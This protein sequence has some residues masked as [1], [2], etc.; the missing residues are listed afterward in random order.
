MDVL[1]QPR[2]GLND[3]AGTSGPLTWPFRLQTLQTGRDYKALTGAW[4]TGTT[5]LTSWA[6]IPEASQTHG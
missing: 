3:P 2:H 1:R 5:W 4:H 6:L